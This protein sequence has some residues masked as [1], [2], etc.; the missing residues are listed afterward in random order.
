MEYTCSYKEDDEWLL[1]VEKE[2]EVIKIQ[3]NVVITKE[4]VIKQVQKMPKGKSPGLDY[5]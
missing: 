5:I 1:K 4:D 2:L 3:N